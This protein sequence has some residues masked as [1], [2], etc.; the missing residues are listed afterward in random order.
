MA[1][2]LGSDFADKRFFLQHLLHR[3]AAC[4]VWIVLDRRSSRRAVLRIR[5]FT[6][7]AKTVRV[8]L[9]RRRFRREIE[10]RDRLQFA[11]RA[12]ISTATEFLELPDAIALLSE[13]AARGSL[14][15]ILRNGLPPLDQALTWLRHA[16]AGLHSLHRQGIMHR[17]VAP[18]HIYVDDAGTARIGSLGHAQTPASLQQDHEP[19]PGAAGYLSPEHALPHP[20]TPTS[21][22][23]G[24]G[25][26][27]FELLTGRAWAISRASITAP[28]QL[29]AAIP[30]WLDDAVL[31]MLAPTPGL[32]PDDAHDPT[33]RF[34]D[35][36][37]V[38]HALEHTTPAKTTLPAVVDDPRDSAVVRSLE[39]LQLQLEATQRKSEQLL[40]A[41]DDLRQ[42]IDQLQRKSAQH[43]TRLQ[44]RTFLAAG[45]G[46]LAGVAAKT[47]SDVLLPA[48][49][50]SIVIDSIAPP[51]PTTT[52]PPLAPTL[53][54]AAA[55][56]VP[57]VVVEL[58]RDIALELV[59]V[60]AGRY[61]LG[62]DPRRDA[63]TKSDEMP[64]QAY[65]LPEFWIGR[66]EVTIAQ[67]AAF[68]KD[69]A[70]V[71]TAE[72]DGY[73]LVLVDGVARELPGADWAHPFGSSSSAANMA[74]FPVTH[75]SWD[76][77]A[78]FCNWLSRRSGLDV[79]LPG[80]VEWEAAARG[81]D[82]RT[83]PWGEDRPESFRANFDMLLKGATPVGT[84]D[85]RFASPCGALDM[86]GNVW[87]WTRSQ[88][89]SYPYE[90]EDGREGLESRSER[91]LRGGGFDSSFD[92][93]RSTQR[94]AALPTAHAYHFGFR[95]RV[96]K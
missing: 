27:A 86:A 82:G 8:D 20:L 47:L 79:A 11:A 65:D 75:V 32:R 7:A 16:A 23:Y 51:S 80:E 73:S 59:R 38:L 42:R 77:A 84:L 76:D 64:Q 54:R 87:E 96:R 34:V 83:Y 49:P 28:S 70:H 15:D 46:I 60:P 78:R 25:C 91:V 36:A 19:H 30:R 94:L 13:Y 50:A 63:Q 39:W 90:Y 29:N 3:G 35:M 26:V 21:D 88:Y 95:V 56:P 74:N 9:L 6:D 52:I 72:R 5:E 62:S 18:S 89:R 93:L 81:P 48:T 37:G 67:F 22:V 10:V 12:H 71:T 17:D 40:G 53:M 41:N 2:A 57:G 4:D 33:K 58:T 44:R 1:L 66:T 45:I 55:T 69:D 61:L 92:M 85:V 43:A 24:L 31:R 68:V 14:A